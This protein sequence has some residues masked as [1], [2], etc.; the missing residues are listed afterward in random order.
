MDHSALTTARQILTVLGIDLDQVR[1]EP[2]SLHDLLDAYIADLS[3]RAT[4]AHCDNV[5]ARLR[6]LI[7][8]LGV[9]HVHELQPHTL[10]LHRAERLKAGCSVRT[11]N[12][13]TDRLRAMLTWAV[14]VGLIATNPVAALPR[15]PENEA[16]KRYRRRAL[17]D[18]EIEALLQ[19]ARDDDLRTRRR[20]SQLP[21]WRALLETGARYGELVRVTWADVDFER[22]L[23]TLR[24][25]N[26]KS[27]RERSIPLLGVL[28][29]ELR[30]LQ[31]QH[32]AVL[33]RTL[34]PSDLVF[35]SPEGCA[36]PRHSVNVTRML[37]RLLEA[38]EIDRLDA[39]GK[40]VDVHALRH[41]FAS[42]LARNGVP[43]TF[44]QRLLGHSTVEMTARVYTH[45]GDEQ[46]RAAIA[47]ISATT[48]LSAFGGTSTRESA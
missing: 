41:S 45:L 43:I 8:D 44:A 10:L 23:L 5:R 32:A 14:R 26:T 47:K 16:T 7:D 17:S 12:L 37:H 21:L 1:P 48:Q 18:A 20:V 13:V 3:T 31:P 39:Q 6:W 42:R 2:R 38:A 29:S 36:W 27:R 40:R 22:A 30:A 33:G 24:A 34:R 19:A 28:V 11:A 9:A 4:P 46:M 35:R 15:L 25:T